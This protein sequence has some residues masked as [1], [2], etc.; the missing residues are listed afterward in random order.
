MALRTL[1]E[2][3]LAARFGDPRLQKSQHYLRV[4]SLAR[5]IIPAAAQTVP[6]LGMTSLVRYS[7]PPLA[8]CATLFLRTD[9]N[10]QDLADLTSK[11]AR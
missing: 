3:R 11:P 1:S 4:A 2:H 8:P 7:P 9:V 10:R 5:S 6:D